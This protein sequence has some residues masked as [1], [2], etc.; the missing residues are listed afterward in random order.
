MTMQA[1]PPMSS[2]AQPAVER[3]SPKGADPPTP[4][5]AS[6]IADV[7][8]PRKSAT[9]DTMDDKNCG[10]PPMK[11]LLEHFGIALCG[12]ATSIL[13]AIAD[14]ALARMVSFDFFTFSLWVVVPVGAMLTGFAAASGYYFGS[15]YFHK[16]ATATLLVQMVVIA[17]ITQLLIYWMGY[18]T[19]VLEDGR[20]VADLVPFGQY[21]DIAL[22][23]A[24]YR[25]GR[26]QSDTGEVGSFGY[27]M[28]VIQFVGFLVGGLAIFMFLRAKA[29]CP[30]CDLYLRPLSKK[31]KTYPNAE[32][33]SAYYDKVFTLPVD[34]ADFAALVKSEAK[35]PKPEQGALLIDTA[36]LGCPKCKVQL[37]E[38]KVKGY[39]GKE[40]KDLNNLDRRV[41]IPSGVD[42]SAVFRG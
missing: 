8:R 7:Q 34:G 29:V 26:A 4:E 3:A 6:Q 36:L 30:N 42:L 25:I 37:V 31:Q 39:N 14:V 24:H 27:W 15:L 23:K 28:A 11:K 32:A 2:A 5:I 10:A 21:L 38:E 35:V 9:A 41:P 17:G 1:L 33:A 20:R 18:T 22:T 19:L 16:R 13:V 40:W 12:L